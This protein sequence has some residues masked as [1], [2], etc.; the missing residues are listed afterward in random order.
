MHRTNAYAAVVISEV[1]AGSVMLAFALGNRHGFDADHLAAIDGLTRWNAAAARRFAAL[2]GLLFSAG[3]VCAIFAIAGL[4]AALSTRLTPPSWLN[5]L[6]MAISGGTLVLLG[7]L[8]L[9]A[10]LSGNHQSG[11]VGL[12][13]RLLAALFR[14]S[15]A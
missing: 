6:G 11:V 1:A 3:H 7:A 2:C 4:L 15:G 9:Q 5:G 10:A 8:N 14:A 13:S 12:R